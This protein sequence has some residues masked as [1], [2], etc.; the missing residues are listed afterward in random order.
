[1]RTLLARAREVVWTAYVA[2]L[3]VVAAIVV[4][5]VLPSLVALVLA[6]IGGAVAL[7]I[8]SLRA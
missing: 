7:A 5:V 4:A 2:L 3:L 6:L 8:L 1:M